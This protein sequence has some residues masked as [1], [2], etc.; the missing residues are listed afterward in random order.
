MPRYFLGNRPASPYSL[1]LA[2]IAGTYSSYVVIPDAQ[3]LRRTSEFTCTAWVKTS[4]TSILGSFSILGKG[5]DGQ[6]TYNYLLAANSGTQGNRFLFALYDGSNNPFIVSDI[7]STP[8]VWY[9]VCGV[10]VNNYID[11]YVNGTKN[12]DS[13]LNTAGLAAGT[14]NT[15]IGIKP[16]GTAGDEGP[17]NGNIK[18]PRIYQRALTPVEIIGLYIG[19]DPVPSNLSA[20]WKFE[21]NT[22]DSSGNSNNGTTVGTSFSY[23]TAIPDVFKY[24]Q[25]VKIN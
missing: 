8:E 17:F 3:S 15:F 11:I 5:L 19:I 12:A 24:S 7:P 9:L 10:A 14:S 23:G 6:E 2:G 16:N 4:G 20:Q 25:R 18:D 1:N 13:V 21:K 22:L